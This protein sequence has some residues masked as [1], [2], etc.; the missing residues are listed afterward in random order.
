MT[1]A[2]QINV[3]FLPFILA[4]ILLGACSAGEQVSYQS[5]GMTHTFIAGKDANKGNFALP[6]YPNARATG[7]VQAKSKDDENSF[8]MLTSSDPLSKISEFYLAEL[9][10]NGWK[11]SQQTVLP[12]QVNISARKDKLEGSIMLSGDEHNKTSITLSVSV[13]SEGIPEVSRE[14]FAPDKVNPPT[15]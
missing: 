14:V 11:V 8:R 7:E 15:D 9:K 6:V 10:K 13:E 5:G 2:T 1:P 3:V 12:T 4:S